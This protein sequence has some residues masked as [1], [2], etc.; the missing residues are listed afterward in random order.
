MP[1][2]MDRHDIPGAKI[3][4][5]FG[6]HQKNIEIQEKYGVKYLTYWWDYENGT[7][8]CLVDWT[9]AA[10]AQSREPAPPGPAATSSEPGGTS[11]AA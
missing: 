5:I 2:F 7:G 6:A 10:C 8:F 9:A 3:E 1:I 4:D 11:Q